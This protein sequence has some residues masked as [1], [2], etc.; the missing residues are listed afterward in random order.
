MAA[1]LVPI[2]Q[3]REMVLASVQPLESERVPV[4][5]ALGRVLATGVQATGD[6]PPFPSSAMDGYALRDGPAGRE[7]SVVGESRA[8]TPSE[9]AVRAGEA[10]RISTGAAVPSGATAVIPQEDVEVHDHAVHTN[11]EVRI[12]EHIRPAG[13][14][15]SAGTIVLPAGTTLRAVELGAAIAAGA[16][17]VQVA[18]RPNVR[19]V[20]TGDELR[21]PGE[22]LR[23]GEIHNSNGP[24]L[25][26]LA[27]EAG[28]LAPPATVL[29]DDRG[30]TETE[31]A[32]AMQAADIVIVSGGV[33]VGPHDH[34]K[35]A[36]AKLGVEEI[37]WGVALQPGKPTWFG[38]RGGTLVFGLPGNPVSAAV[39]FTLFARPAIAAMQGADDPSALDGQAVLGVAVPRNR[40]REQ[41]IRVRLERR[42]GATI[43]IPNGA[44]DSHVITSL[45]GAD[46]LA[47]I[48]AG[49]GVLDEGS[50]VALAPAPH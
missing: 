18:R 15:M 27:A 32:S 35:P 37:F 43:A 46:A 4:L 50:T 23:P 30:A 42:D 6:V 34:V 9:R 10:I 41:A 22:P 14:V 20:C 47:L 48:P 44:Q 11:R 45:V 17:T 39:T 49:E 12:G 8:G 26:A 19:V 24:M 1:P 33:S 7:L 29:R 21:E 13:E 36:L 38:T 28:A 25:V 40:R 5:D 31:L 2:A 3:A 16:G